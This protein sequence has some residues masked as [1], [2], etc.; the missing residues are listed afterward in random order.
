MSVMAIKEP[1]SSIGENVEPSV[2]LKVHK[3]P[4]HGDTKAM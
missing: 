4:P 1:K 3:P 2:G